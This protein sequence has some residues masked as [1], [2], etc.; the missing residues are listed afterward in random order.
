[1]PQQVVMIVVSMFLIEILGRRV[2]LSVTA[3]LNMVAMAAMCIYFVCLRVLALDMAA[4]KWLPLA[5]L[6][7]FMAATG[8]GVIPVSHVLQGELLSQRAKV[9]KRD[10]EFELMLRNVTTLP[11]SS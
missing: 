9:S 10:I 6:V 11:S 1:M 8:A 7:L 2:Q 3:F 5:A 4:F